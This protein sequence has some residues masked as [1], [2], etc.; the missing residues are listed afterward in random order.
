MKAIEVNSLT[1]TFGHLVAVDHISFEVEEGEIFGF[2]GVNGCG[3]TTA[4]MML[5]TALNPSSGIA[6]VCGYDIIKERDKVRESIGVVFQRLSVDV[7]LTGREN[8]DFHARMYH[9]DRKTREERVSYVLDLVGLRSKQDMLVKH[10]SGGMQRKLEVARGMI[11]YPKVLFLD[12]PTL[13]LDV[14]TRRVLWDYAKKLNREFGISIL[15]NTHYIEE[16]DYLCDRIAILEQGKIVI[17]D[18][19]AGLKD[20]VG[21]SLLSVKLSQGSSDEL[22]KLLSQVDWVKKVDQC[23]GWLEL[24]VEN[25][26]KKIPEVVRLAQERDFVV[27]SIS[28]HKPTLEDAFLWY[29]GKAIREDKGGINE[30]RKTR[31]VRR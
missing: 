12:E 8:L 11:N 31:R 16:A 13:G 5:A 14:Q 17:V 19:P 23:D 20:S 3:K 25:G 1:K 26:G 22:T 15:L 21:D 10:Y 9:L 18:T 27:S 2:L 6:T 7:N 24:S 29:T 4:M 30:L 28:E